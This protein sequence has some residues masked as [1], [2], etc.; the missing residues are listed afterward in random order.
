MLILICLFSITLLWFIRNVN[1][2][3]LPGLKGRYRV[4]G[5]VTLMLIDGAA[6]VYFYDYYLQG[7]PYALYYI[8]E[9]NR[10]F[11]RNKVKINNKP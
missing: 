5:V 10:F 7:L 9:L 11:L 2:Y 4:F 1:K 6:M 3:L 8:W